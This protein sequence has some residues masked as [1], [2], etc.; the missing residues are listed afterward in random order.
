MLALMNRLSS[1]LSHC[2]LRAL[3]MPPDP[4][5]TASSFAGVAVPTGGAAYISNR[6]DGTQRRFEPEAI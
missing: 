1:D 4:S 3:R 2:T 5:F 6:R